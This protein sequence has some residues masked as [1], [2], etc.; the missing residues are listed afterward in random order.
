MDPVGVG[1][2]TL[3]ILLMGFLKLVLGMS[4]DIN[5]LYES[6]ECGSVGG[7]RL[8]CAGPGISHEGCV[9]L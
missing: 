2:F 9:N 5:I 4:N 6:I 1:M 3:T 7:S 8:G